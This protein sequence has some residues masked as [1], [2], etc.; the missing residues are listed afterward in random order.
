MKVAGGMFQEREKLE[1]VTSPPLLFSFFPLENPSSAFVRVIG[2]VRSPAVH[3]SQKPIHTDPF[4]PSARRPLFPP[5][6]SQNMF[7][8]LSVDYCCFIKAILH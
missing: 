1:E 5:F 6:F 4:F 7:F 8:R 2:H 3:N